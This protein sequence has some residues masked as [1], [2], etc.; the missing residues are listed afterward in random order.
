LRN[1]S[2]GGYGFFDFTYGEVDMSFAYGSLT[3]VGESNG[4]SDTDDGGSAIQ[5]GINVLGTYP[6]DLGGFTVFP[7]FGLG[8]NAV[9]S[10]TVDGS[11]DDKPGDLSQF[12]IMFGG[13]L[14]YFFS[15]A[16]FLRAELLFNIR[17]AATWQDDY[18][19]VMEVYKLIDSNASSDST[20]GMG[21][22]VKVGVGYRFF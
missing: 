4:K 14:D 3:M 22:R 13:G 7:L 10:H 19:K 17:F 6:F 16:L 5:L 18:K 2:F 12:N 20:W 15:D 21:P 9:L 11:S 1:I 8:Y